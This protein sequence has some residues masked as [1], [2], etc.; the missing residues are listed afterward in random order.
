MVVVNVGEES[1]NLDL[2]YIKKLFEDLAI[3]YILRYKILVVLFLYFTKY[4]QGCI[5]SSTKTLNYI[6]NRNICVIILYRIYKLEKRIYLGHKKGLM[7][8]LLLIHK[9]YTPFIGH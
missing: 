4:V 2:I 5:M 9:T 7:Q 3:N 8:M 1:I 6:L